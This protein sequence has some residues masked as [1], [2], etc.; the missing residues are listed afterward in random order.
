[1]SDTQEQILLALIQTIPELQ[2][3]YGNA[4][5]ALDEDEENG[6]I[7]I[8]LARGA[9]EVSI[10]NIVFENI[11][12]LS[13]NGA[14]IAKAF[15][16]CIGSPKFELEKIHE[17]TSE[18]EILWF[19]IDR[20]PDIEK[21]NEKSKTDE[22]LLK[23]FADRGAIEAHIKALLEL[24]NKKSKELENIKQVHRTNIATL[25]QNGGDAIKALDCCILSD[26]FKMPEDADA[27]MPEIQKM[28]VDVL[29]Q[30]VSDVNLADEESKTLLD[31][32]KQAKHTYIFQ[33]LKANGATAPWQR[34]CVVC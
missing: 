8:L 30:N 15:H 12:F 3:M 26:D 13:E 5:L 29:I 17:K 28:I 24:D 11:K 1:M 27:D 2:R 23:I 31:R 10:D 20:H 18:K 25:S 9:M 19:L 7:K 32:S 33:Q 34:G 14:D 22:T 6:L 16:H 4:E 21:I